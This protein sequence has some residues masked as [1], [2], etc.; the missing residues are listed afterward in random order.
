MKVAFLPVYPNPYQR[1]LRAAL[2]GEGVAVEFLDGLPAPGWLR[3]HRGEVDVLHYHWLS[4]LYMNR[5][6]TPVRAAQFVARLGLARRLGYRVVWTAH[7]TLPHQAAI[8]PLH[9]AMR[10]LMMRHADCVIVHC[11][12]ARRELLDRFPREGTVE[13]IPHGSFETV[14]PTRLSRGEARDQ[15]GLD[16]DSFVFLALGNI[17]AYKGL[18]QFVAAFG[19]VAGPGDTALIAGRDRD[20][21]LVAHLRRAAAGD[22]RV[23]L[24][25]GF[26]P[27]EAMG[28]YLA[29]ADVMVAPFRAILT[30]GS[31]IASLSAGL[32]VI[33]PARGCMPELIGGAGVVY[34]PEEADG[35]ARALLTARQ[36]D[37]TVMSAAARR[38]AAGLDWG[39]IG[40]RTAAVY[41]SCGAGGRAG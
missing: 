22:R 25:I 26:V 36:S 38:I 7:N 41:R 3:A 15:L 37:L 24:W 8:R 21:R 14:Y 27:D 10:R 13:V 30:S 35:L 5:W 39:S 34:A 2:E 17:A 16:G 18:D 28:L 6:G 33:V 1:L 40:R 11:Q 12:A 9:V 31:V 23:H 20:S 29:A 32:P 19:R 4:G